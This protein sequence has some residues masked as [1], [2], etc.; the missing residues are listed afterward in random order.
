MLKHIEI[1]TEI[2][3]ELADLVVEK[4]Q[5][6]AAYM[7]NSRE[8][9]WR[10]DF[11]PPISIEAPES[12]QVQELLLNS[13]ITEAND[14]MAMMYG[15]AKGKEIIGKALKE[16]MLPSDS[17]NVEATT[18]FIRNGYRLNDMMTHE[19]K[20]DG[21]TG[22][23]MNSIVPSIENDMLLFMWGSSLDITVLYNTQE[24]LQ[25]SCKELEDKK[26]TLEEKNIALKELITQ[27][28]LEKND[29]KNRIMS[30]IENVILPSLEKIKLNKNAK[31]YI[32]QH[33]KA[34]EDLTS[35]FGRKVSEVRMKL[36][37]REIEVC[38]MV[39]NGLTNKEI[40]KLL[41]IALHTVEKHR[42]MARNKLGLAN[43]GV[44]LRSYLISPEM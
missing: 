12:Q 33:H 13:I 6:F 2:E 42:R 10:I 27:I 31:E 23:Y 32:E 41:G 4:E 15:Y 9:V 39:K 43:K 26:L 17:K 18:T 34:L 3:R 29:L 25:R 5:R 38:N 16:F 24:E 36:T 21:S 20:A 14:A 44:N 19:K 22:V 30:N 8:A 37:P 28:E 7:A 11:K 1:K 40:S 35:S